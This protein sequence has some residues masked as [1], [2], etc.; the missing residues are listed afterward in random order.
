M[1]LLTVSPEIKKEFVQIKKI[2][3]DCKYNQPLPN[4]NFN[5]KYYEPSCCTHEK[6][7]GNKI[8]TVF[9]KPMV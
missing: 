9:L 1:R 4:T 3:A 8:R 2:A 7:T 5:P 6:L